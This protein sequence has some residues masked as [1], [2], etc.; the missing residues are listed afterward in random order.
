MIKILKNLAK[1]LRILSKQKIINNYAK[2]VKYE[3]LEKGLKK[4]QKSFKVKEKLV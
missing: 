1:V 3:L 4:S 2:S